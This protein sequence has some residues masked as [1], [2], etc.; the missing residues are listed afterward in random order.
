MNE[1][2]TQDTDNIQ[3]I[4][5]VPRDR[6]AIT[7]ANAAKSPG[8]KTDEGKRRSSRNALKHGL[9]GQT[10]V[11]PGEDMQ[12]YEALAKSFH[13]DLAPKGAVQLHLCN[14]LADISWRLNRSRALEHNQL[15]ANQPDAGLLSTLSMHGQRLSREFERTLKQFHELQ[16]QRRA[17]EEA[18]LAEAEILMELHDAQFPNI[19][20]PLYYPPNDGFVFSL[21]QV[22]TRRDRRARKKHAQEYAEG[23]RA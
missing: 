13:K 3:T 19:G 12:A 20:D 14:S 10:V 18:Q 7:R 15:N 9:T 1:I 22:E 23:R 4:D 17:T 5:S 21:K 11:M 2:N 16:A 8:P 6:A